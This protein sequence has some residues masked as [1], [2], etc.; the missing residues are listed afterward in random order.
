MHGQVH[1][2]LPISAGP[3]VTRS[4]SHEAI[5]P[6]RVTR[7]WPFIA[8]TC[9]SGRGH[10]VTAVSPLEPRSTAVNSRSSHFET[11]ATWPLLPELAS[12]S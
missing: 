5:E 2:I 9:V 12:C 4:R 1:L 10:A 3:A 6:R 7:L 11:F 8:L